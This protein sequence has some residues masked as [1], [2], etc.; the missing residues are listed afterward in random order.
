MF[1]ETVLV[2][3]A[4]NIYL[5]HAGNL[6]SDR[7]Q[8]SDCPARAPSFAVRSGHPAVWASDGFVPPNSAHSIGTCCDPRRLASRRMATLWRSP[9]G[10]RGGTASAGQICWKL[11]HGQAFRRADDGIRTRDPH[12]GKVMRYQLRYI[13]IRTR[14]RVKRIA[15]RLG[16]RRIPMSGGDPASRSVP[17]APVGSCKYAACVQL[18]ASFVGFM[19]RFRQHTVAA[20]R[21]RRMC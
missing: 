12:L 20:E 21:P 10:G 15:D 6:G 19:F 13:R 14:R 3:V 2:Y 5:D 11:L 8:T 7:P 17:H 9:Y 1:E 4:S 18:C 16:E